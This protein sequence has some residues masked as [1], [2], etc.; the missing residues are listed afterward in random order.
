MQE[1]SAERHD[2]MQQFFYRE[3]RGYSCDSIEQHK[4][5]DGNAAGVTWDGHKHFS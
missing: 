1:D 3:E 4:P 5:F 2:K